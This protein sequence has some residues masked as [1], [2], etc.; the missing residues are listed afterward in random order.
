MIVSAGRWKLNRPGRK[1][2]DERFRGPNGQTLD[3]SLP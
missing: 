2:A 1:I 3:E